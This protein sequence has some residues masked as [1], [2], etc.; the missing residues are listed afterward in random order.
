MK[1]V[2]RHAGAPGT[3]TWDN[4]F[5]HDLLDDDYNLLGYVREDIRSDRSVIATT[6][7]YSIKFPKQFSTLKEAK[8]TL[9]AHFV[10]KKLE[11]V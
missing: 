5:F 3:W 2:K 1:W 6:N 7:D 8:D 4:V 10:L 9:I 11:D